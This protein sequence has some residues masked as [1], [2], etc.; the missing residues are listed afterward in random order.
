MEAVADGR[1]T[2]TELAK[3]LVHERAEA[4][5]EIQRLAGVLSEIK[6]RAEK[7]PDFDI[8]DAWFMAREALQGME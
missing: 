6:D 5:K 2:D 3:R 1:I 7:Q 4:A 8:G